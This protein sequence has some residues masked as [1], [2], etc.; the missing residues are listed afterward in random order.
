MN[1]THLTVYMS[2]FLIK[3][4]L[5]LFFL[6][7]IVSCVYTKPLQKQ[8]EKEWL[9]RPTREVLSAYGK[10]D[11]VNIKDVPGTTMFIYVTTDF[12]PDI[13]PNHTSKDFWF[14][15]DSIIYKVES[16]RW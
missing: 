6:P 11:Y 12:T 7:I 16:Y 5:I 4:P 9:G 13:P 3:Y 2:K 8:L 1:K 10:P 14:K 15:N